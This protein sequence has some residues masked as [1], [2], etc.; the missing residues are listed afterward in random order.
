MQQIYRHSDEHFEVF[1]TVFSPQ[2]ES[3]THAG[4]VTV[5][6]VGTLDDSVRVSSVCRSRT[7]RRHVGAEKVKHPLLSGQIIILL[8][9]P[10]PT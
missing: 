10:E 5:V 4:M 2:G 6:T 9:K 1:T 7:R 8:A 3:L